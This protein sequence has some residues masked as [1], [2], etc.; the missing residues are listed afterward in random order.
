MKAKA[1][2]ELS[3]TAAEEGDKAGNKRE[4]AVIP[5]PLSPRRPLYTHLHAPKIQWVPAVSFASVQSQTRV[6]GTLLTWHL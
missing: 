6:E 3:C 2:T 4:F 5:L 1:G